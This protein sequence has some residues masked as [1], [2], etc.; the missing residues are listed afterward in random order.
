MYAI[1]KQNDTIGSFEERNI[2]LNDLVHP[3]FHHFYIPIIEGH[4]LKVGD[5]YHRDTQ[6]WEIV[7]IPEPEEL[8]EVIPAPYQPTN[9][10]VAQMI[11]DL[12]A[13]LI[14]AGVI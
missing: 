11:S 10:E 13:D 12:Q 6:A 9:A 4:N 3:D 7:E 8:E 1:L 5:I 2:P 14:I